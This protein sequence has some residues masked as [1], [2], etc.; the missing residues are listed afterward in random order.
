MA[1]RIVFVER[2]DEQNGPATRPLRR[3]RPKVPNLF[4]DAEEEE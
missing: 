4:D 2:M 1:G 3:E